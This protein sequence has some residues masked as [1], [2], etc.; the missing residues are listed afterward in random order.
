MTGRASTIALC[1]VAIL[2]VA[3]GG[4]AVLLCQGATQVDKVTTADVAAAVGGVTASVEQ[5]IAA[6]T[7]AQTGSTPIVN[8]ARLNGLTSD[9]FVR[10]D[11]AGTHHFNCQ[12]IG[13]CPWSSE[14][15][16]TQ[17]KRGREVTSGEGFFD[18]LVFLPDGARITAFRGIIDDSS[19]TGK[20]VCYL[21]AAPVNLDVSGTSP[22][23]TPE[24]GD[25]A[26]PGNVILEDTTIEPSVI[27]NSNFSYLAECW[28]SGPGKLALKGVSIEYTIGGQPAS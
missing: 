25:T 14:T 7:A 17:T 3:L 22:A 5:R 1:L 19:P 15:K 12:G 16:Y 26:T 8:A 4:S 2:G 13:M 20:A 23:Y 24:S 10:A 21:L 6:V 9:Q 18:C 27:D 11:A 28:L